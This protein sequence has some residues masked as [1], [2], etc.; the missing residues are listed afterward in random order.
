VIKATFCG[1]KKLTDSDVWV[2]EVMSTSSFDIE[3][4]M[5]KLVMKSSACITMAKPIDVN[6]LTHLWHILLTSKLFAY[7]FSECF[8]LVE[9]A[10][11][12]VIGS[13]Q[14]E[15]C[16]ISLAFYKSKLRN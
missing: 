10:M 11:V 1:P 4:S 16:F 5:F 7:S 9:I 2:P 6:P 14:D 8:K 15:R 3:Q 12:H 13:V